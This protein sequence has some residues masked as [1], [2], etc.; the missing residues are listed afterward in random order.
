MSGPHDLVGTEDFYG[1][2][3]GLHYNNFRY[4][5]RDKAGKEK[6][7]HASPDLVHTQCGLLMIGNQ[8]AMSEDKVD[9]PK[10]TG[11]TEN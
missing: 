8:W 4:N 5:V 6:V 9:C 11:K 7:V 2:G 3:V 10:C 1:K